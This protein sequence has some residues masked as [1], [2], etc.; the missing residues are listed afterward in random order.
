MITTPLTR[1][2]G[3]G[4]WAGPRRWAGPAGA[5]G[6]AVAV[7]AG[8]AALGLSRPVP[9]PDRHRG[10]PSCTFP[11]APSAL[12]IVAGPGQPAAQLGQLIV[13]TARPSEDLTIVRTG[14][15]SP[16]VTA[17][18]SPAPASVAVPVRPRAP[19]PD[20]TSYQEA[21][22]RTSLSAWQRDRAEARAEVTHRTRAMV[23]SWAHEQHIPTAHRAG[24]SGASL[25][26]EA[27][28]AA[29]AMDGLTDQ[30]GQRFGGHRVVV[31][32]PADLR[33]TPRPGELTGDDVLVI[34]P[35]L[36][37]LEAATATQQKL[38]AAGAIW[39]AVLGPE[40]TA[41]RVSRLV[42][43]GLTL[44]LSREVLS[45]RTLFSNDSARL[46][47]A[48]AHVLLALVPLL[49]RPGL[50]AVV[51]GYASS[52][53]TARHNQRLSL[54]RASS[55]V[56]FLAAQGVPE[57]KLIPVGHGS[58]DPVPDGSAASDRRV[59]VVIEQ[60]AATAA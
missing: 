2:S 46:R 44:Q 36:P 48:A 30:S 21:E 28:L 43:D 55:V 8:C 20:A 24:A 35:F 40:T 34:V 41:A 4:R 29:S 38:V 50:T 49:Q 18:A 16:A 59:V 14:P 39:A 23:L 27:R 5:S 26:A 53:G 1:R 10:R 45:G 17:S 60:P 11:A 37:G 51:N 31:L 9:A 32:F 7:T 58:R 19:G 6:L 12:V 15:G 47:P 22:Y 13:R 56:A 3:P 52:P 54:A 33:G 42:S 57:D 25:T